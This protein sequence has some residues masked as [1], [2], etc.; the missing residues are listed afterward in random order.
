MRVEDKL[1]FFFLTI[2]CLLMYYDGRPSPSSFFLNG[3]GL[4]FFLR[5]IYLQLRERK[6]K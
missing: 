6:K 3:V 4:G 5:S 1:G 2:S